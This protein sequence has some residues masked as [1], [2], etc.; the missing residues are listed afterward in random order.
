VGN[1]FVLRRAE[2]GSTI[3]GGRTFR[4]PVVVHSLSG[5]VSITS[6]V[7]ANLNPFRGLSGTI[8]IESSLAANLYVI[9]S[10]SG[11]VDAVVTLVAVLLTNIPEPFRPPIGHASGESI[12]TAHSRPAEVLSHAHGITATPILPGRGK[13]SRTPLGVGRLTAPQPGIA[14][15]HG[16]D[17]PRPGNAGVAEAI[18]G[19]ATSQGTPPG[20]ASSPPQPPSGTGKKARTRGGEAEPTDKPLSPGK[21][22]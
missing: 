4:A 21:A 13:V 9:W 16:A 12:L 10:L 2:G 15:G 8:D 1:T 22:G 6:T 11:T 17:I 20:A 3:R 18:E 14:S 5:T 19:A 7:S